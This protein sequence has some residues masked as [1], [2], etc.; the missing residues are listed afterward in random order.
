MFSVER[1]KINNLKQSNNQTIIKFYLI[2]CFSEYLG[3]EM[4]HSFR[5][6]CK[7]VLVSKYTDGVGSQNPRNIRRE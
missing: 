3:V 6:Y 7:T 2:V 1:E 4:L 5:Q